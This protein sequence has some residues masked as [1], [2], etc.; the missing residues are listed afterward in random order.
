[1]GGPAAINHIDAFARIGIAPR[2]APNA[3]VPTA[4]LPPPL[5]RFPPDHGS[6]S[7]R[8]RGPITIAFPPDG[9]VVALER[10]D[11]TRVPLVARVVGRTADTWMLNGRPLP[12][13]ANRRRA[14]IEVGPGRHILTVVTADGASERV[15]FTAE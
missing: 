11:G 7:A 5:R 13:R 6:G 2:P 14:E 3:A 8:D 10:H 1:M 4:E 9:A 12:A 15:Q